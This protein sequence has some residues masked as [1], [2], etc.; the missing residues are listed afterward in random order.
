MG[1]KRN[2]AAFAEASKPGGWFEQAGKRNAAAFA[3]ASSRQKTKGVRKD[4]KHDRRCKAQTLQRA[5]T[6][7][8]VH[9]TDEQVQ[10]TLQ[11]RYRRD[12]SGH[13]VGGEAVGSP[14]G[15]AAQPQDSD[16][17]L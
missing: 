12:K 9:V 17:D 14:S 4:G 10:E 13:K 11:L 2:A 15:A 8:D 3:V 6:T 16:E 7:F 1:G 5:A